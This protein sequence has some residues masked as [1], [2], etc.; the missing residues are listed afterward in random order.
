MAGTGSYGQPCPA[1]ST[2]VLFMPCN[3]DSHKH[4][5][6][7]IAASTEYSRVGLHSTRACI[8]I[9][10]DLW[11]QGRTARERIFRAERDIGT[12]RKLLHNRASLPTHNCEIVMLQNASKT[13][14]S[15]PST[16][17][18]SKRTLSHNC[19]LILLVILM[20]VYHECIMPSVSQNPSM[21]PCS[22]RQHS[23]LDSL[24]SSCR[25]A[26]T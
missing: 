14:N 11:E 22:R 7:R 8:D 25:R 10:Q 9:L 21:P 6:R 18:E 4:P 23:C 16:I 20:P 1:F 5:L 15:R 13:W 2:T 19:L 3:K 24:A 12:F 17:I 26:L